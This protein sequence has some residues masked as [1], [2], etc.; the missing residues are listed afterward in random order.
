M[1]LLEI[2]TIRSPSCSV[3]DEILE[4]GRCGGFSW[5]PNCRAKRDLYF[6]GRRPRR[7]RRKYIAAESPCLYRGSSCGYIILSRRR[8]IYFHA[9]LEVGTGEYDRP[10]GIYYNT[11]LRRGRCIICAYYHYTVRRMTSKISTPTT[12]NHSENRRKR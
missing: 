11:Q 8:I 12:R 1:D 6:F 3:A 7:D 5:V 2:M 10:E 9:T 4:E